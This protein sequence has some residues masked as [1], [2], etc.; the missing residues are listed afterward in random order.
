MPPTLDDQLGPELTLVS[1]PTPPPDPFGMDDGFVVEFE[2]QNNTTEEV[3]GYV[4]FDVESTPEGNFTYATAT[5]PAGERAIVATS[6]ESSHLSTMGVDTP[7]QTYEFEW[8]ITGMGEIFWEAEAVQTTD[9]PEPEFDPSAVNITNCDVSPNEVD[10]GDSMDMSAWIQNDNATP[11]FTQVSFF[12]GNWQFNIQGTIA[13]NTTTELT[14]TFSAND[15]HI[16][17]IGGSGV[18]DVNADLTTVEAG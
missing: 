2:L 12:V 7:G 17:E 18:Y 11:A 4:F 9:E 1:V 14:A 5:I 6:V 16:S 15:Q 10:R 13:S 8:G 3:S